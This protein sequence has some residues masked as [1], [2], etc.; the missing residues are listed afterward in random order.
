[1][2]EDIMSIANVKSRHHAKLN[3]FWFTKEDL[4]QEIII[5]LLKALHKFDPSKAYHEKY[6]LYFSRCADN[7]VADLKRKHLYFHKL[8]CKTCPMWDKIKSKRGE[9]DCRKYVNKDS[10]DLYERYI[11]LY[12]S[13]Y[14][15]GSTYG[16]YTTSKPSLYDGDSSSE[17]S[18]YMHSTSGTSASEYQEAIFE[19]IDFN[20][21]L[22]NKLTGLAYD[23]FKLLV[24]FNYDCSKLQDGDLDILKDEISHIYKRGGE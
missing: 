1:M 9:H 11:T 10:C 15:L 7:I 17:V 18:G 3:K 16:N 6:M 23:V 22:E 14:M 20:E 5:K 19:N 24:G 13:K 8:P 2:W 21:F 4:E 12:K